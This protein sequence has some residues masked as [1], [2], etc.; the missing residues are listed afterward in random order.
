MGTIHVLRRLLP[1]SSH[2]MESAPLLS[3]L[4]THVTSYAHAPVFQLFLYLLA[5]LPSALPLSG[6]LLSP[7]DALARHRTPEV[8]A[9]ALRC[10]VAFEA[11]TLLD[12]GLASLFDPAAIV[13]TPALALVGHAVLL[14]RPAYVVPRL[15][16][17]PTITAACTV[18]SFASLLALLETSEETLLATPLLEVRDQLWAA[19]TWCV[20]AR[21]R[22]HYGNAGQTFAALE[23]LLVQRSGVAGRLLVE[24]VHALELAILHACHP[25][26]H[27]LMD[28]KA[29]AFY[30]TNRKVCE[31]WLLR[32]RPALV[33]LCDATGATS[34]MAYHALSLV[35]KPSAAALFSAA[36]ALCDVLDVPSLVGFG[37]YATAHTLHVPW[38]HAIVQEAQLLYEAAAASYEHLLAPLFAL[39]ERHASGMHLAF[40][41]EAV[42]QATLRSL[43]TT[44]AEA[45]LEHVSLAS[46]L[47]R[48]AKCYA[49]VHAWPSV[50]AL[51]GKA[52]DLAMFLGHLQGC[53]ED[54]LRV[55]TDM[56][57]LAASWDL[58][59]ALVR[60][61]TNPSLRFSSLPTTLPPLQEWT[62]LSVVDDALARVSLAPSL[63]DVCLDGHAARLARQLKLF[64]LDE[65]AVAS[66]KGA[67]VS[68]RLEA[69]LVHVKCL[70]MLR[71][72]ADAVPRLGAY[73]RDASV[74]LPLLDVSRYLGLDQCDVQL[75]MVRLARKQGNI[76]LAASLLAQLADVPAKAA[77]VQYERA[78]LDFAC[79]APANAVRRLFPVTPDAHEVHVKAHRKIASWLQDKDAWRGEDEAMRAAVVGGDATAQ[80]EASLAA[81]TQVAPTSY[82]SWLA[83]SDY[84]FA[85]STTAS[86]ALASD[87]AMALETLLADAALVPH[88]HA[89]RASLM[90]MTQDDDDDRISFA[91][92]CESLPDSAALNQL[93]ALY[94]RVR[95]RALTSHKAAIHGYF[96]YLHTASPAS[97]QSHGLIV[98]LRLLV[99]LVRWGH[100]PSLQAALD[101]GVESSPITPWERIVPQLLSRLKHPNATV[102]ARLTCILR[103]LASQRPQ[104]M[105]YPAVVE[106]VES[107]S[108]LDADLVAGVTEVVKELRRVALLYED[109]WVSLLTKLTTD[110]KQRLGQQTYVAI[111]KP[112][113]SALESLSAETWQRPP[114]TPHERWFVLHF[115]PAFEAAL[116]RLRASCDASGDALLPRAWAPFHDLLK[117]LQPHQ[118]RLSLPLA[119]ISPRLA[120]LRAGVPMPGTANALVDIARIDPT[121]HVLATKTRPKTLVLH[122]TDGASYQYLL[123]SREDLHLDERIMQLLATINSSL[124]AD[125]DARSMDLGARHY[126]VVPL[127]NDA[128]LIQM[129]PNVTPL[130][131]L[132]TPPSS[133]ASSAAA[134]SSSSS[135]TAPFYAALKALGVKDA[136]PSGRPTWSHAVLQQAYEALVHETKRRPNALRQEMLAT[137]S[138]ID[139]FQRKSTRF[140][141][142]VAVMS[143]IGYLIGLG[144]RHLDNILLCNATGDVVHIDYNVC[145]EKGR[146]LKVPEV[147]PFRLTTMLLGA[148]GATGIEGTFRIAME[149][150]LSVA[151]DDSATKE[152]ILTL[153]EAFVYDPLLD[154][155]D[156]PAKLWRMEMNVQLSLFASRAHERGAETS[157]VWEQI[158]RAWTAPTFTRLL[159][160]ARPLVALADKVASL[161]R[162]VAETTAQLATADA[163]M[164]ALQDTLAATTLDD[165]DDEDKT[166]AFARA[167]ERLEAFMGRCSDE[168][169]Q[170]DA[171][172]SLPP[173]TL[174][175]GTLDGLPTLASVCKAP[176][177]QTTV[178]AVDSAAIAL[179]EQLGALA[180]RLQHALSW[181]ESVRHTVCSSHRGPTI[182]DEWRAYSLD[183]IS[184]ARKDDPLKHLA[185]QKARSLP[186]LLDDMAL[187]QPLQYLFRLPAYLMH[188]RLRDVLLPL[189]NPLH[190][191][192]RS[193]SES[194]HCAPLRA[195]LDRLHA[196]LATVPR[197][198]WSAWLD[199]LGWEPNSLDDG[200]FW[201]APLHRFYG[202]ALSVWRLPGMHQL[203]ALCCQLATLETTWSDP[204]AAYAI[205][206]KWVTCLLTMSRLVCANAHEDALQSV[207]DTAAASVLDLAYAAL[208]SVLEGTIRHEWKLRATGLDRAWVTALVSPMVQGPL[209]VDA[210]LDAV[211]LRPMLDILQDR[212]HYLWDREVAAYRTALVMHTR[213][214]EAHHATLCTWVQQDTEPSR[215][216]V[217]HTLSETEAMVHELLLRRDALEDALIDAQ[218]LLDAA[219]SRRPHLKTPLES[220]RKELRSLMA[221]ADGIEL[222]I[223]WVKYLDSAF[224]DSHSD[225]VRELDEEG[226]AVI[227][228]YM[229]LEAATAAHRAAVRNRK[230]RAAALERERKAA[231]DR[232]HCLHAA[233]A[234]ARA[235][236]DKVLHR[237]LPSLAPLLEQ[238]QQSWLPE[239]FGALS[240]NPSHVLWENERLVRLLSKSLKHGVLPDLQAKLKALESVSR[241]LHGIVS[242]LE[243]PARALQSLSLDA[244]FGRKKTLANIVSGGAAVEPSIDA[245]TQLVTALRHVVHASTQEDTAATVVL[246]T[247]SAMGGFFDIAH[248]ALDLSK[249]DEHEWSD[250]D[251]DDDRSD[252]GDNEDNDDDDDDDNDASND[253][254][255]VEERNRY[256]LQVLQR[257]TEKL[258]GYTTPNAPPLSCPA[259]VEWL[260]QQ[261]T[262]VD[263]LCVMYEGWT[264]WI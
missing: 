220:T 258:D 254:G 206:H 173:R 252:D 263:N 219:V 44:L 36:T 188:R 99:F 84:W 248:H 195:E 187:A 157:A 33:R 73:E 35:R 209:T 54:T 200:D 9:F 181:M 37:A 116:E 126:S 196:E 87:D 76:G 213:Q 171:G 24:F 42:K 225:R 93:H 113:L 151:R 101:D 153:L 111:L 69:T 239:A 214:L 94:Q 156:G 250:D 114:T 238:L 122:G 57:S 63:A 164:D 106:S 192:R 155:K 247:N 148:L 242:A 184:H 138:S 115:G 199:A 6:A 180:P 161:A 16:R 170:H 208:Q 137:S 144:D 1:H 55:A 226:L 21:L 194:V 107:T 81:A 218:P 179:N 139:E 102:V 92:C 4:A 186:S 211:E 221:Q 231:Y 27:I 7:F 241:R 262:S 5:H 202:C 79:G 174:Q 29:H 30:A 227:T 49:N 91:T 166:R 97:I 103:R 23:R 70:E 255:R 32:I 197:A 264:P 140:A 121:A 198:E 109:A 205:E 50:S 123:K 142:S 25:R 15:Y 191:L 165:D 246:L 64:T 85:A 58:E 130:F 135:P 40:E 132:H 232:L 59:H 159:S 104:L 251:D 74:Y 118:R 147:V 160:L 78:C 253:V 120:S 18:T 56:T 45:G 136:S 259:H 86:M 183:L 53:T 158:Q 90:H 172:V 249:Q 163:E 2:S 230:K 41:S 62:V 210:L 149:R 31:D 131:Q 152:S 229:T 88:A 3:T 190:P 133:S 119:E 244:A 11:P 141:R 222:T 168:I 257:V 233:H 216:S 71:R 117:R 175:Y 13:S 128:G 52:L 10:L 224:R 48:W 26:R 96:T 100:E 89:L 201:H 12:V 17:A 145:F 98:T 68:Q 75:Q 167:T 243:A 146:K 14:P 125:K 177:L 39:S 217:L 176:R 72:P 77:V 256:G 178:S 51:M 22:T 60:T 129:V 169:E 237:T 228:E 20:E 34:L 182:M 83:W 110:D 19:A 46:L 193:S 154:W 124:S 134:A 162:E 223:E 204:S 65:H 95:A 108:L 236:M 207:L 80:I 260:L 215:A 261:A 245:R 43:H 47:V 112:V 185:L 212:W 105:V 240:T 143:V 66:V 127:A 235:E 38:L 82:Q 150:T 203:R 67:H 234:N 28:A 8:R 61:K 189:Y